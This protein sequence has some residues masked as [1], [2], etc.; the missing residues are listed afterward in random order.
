MVIKRDKFYYIPLL[1]TLEKILSTE[2]MLNEIMSP[3]TKDTNLRDFCD[4]SLYASHPLF[5]NDQHALQIIGYYDELE[6]ANPLGSYVSKHKLGCIFF[7]L[8]NITPRFRCTF[9]AT[10][11]VAVAKSE[12]ISSYGTDAFLTPFVNDLKT[13]FLDDL[14]VVL[15]SGEKQIYGALLA[16]HQL[17]GFKMSPSFSLRICRSCMVTGPQSQHITNEINC[18]PRSPECHEQQC[19]LSIIRYYIAISQQHLAFL[20]DPFLKTYQDFL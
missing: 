5:S 12:D 3:R 20:A 7:F 4:G 14:T 10:Y 1:D 18:L 2:G 16:S 6:V 11:L 15:D 9:L 19:L 13:L 8:G 17:G